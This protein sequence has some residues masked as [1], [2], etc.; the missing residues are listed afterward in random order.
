MP[1]KFLEEIGT[2][3]AGR[4][5]QQQL[6]KNQ[7]VRVMTGAVMPGGADTVVIQEVVRNE[8]ARI[9]VTPV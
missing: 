7:C 8:G 9:V 3:L 5:F 6:E 1:Y 2:A 4:P